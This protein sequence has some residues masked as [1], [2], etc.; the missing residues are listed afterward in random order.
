MSAVAWSDGLKQVTKVYPLAIKSKNWPEIARLAKAG[1]VDQAK[2]LASRGEMHGHIE[3]GNI[4]ARRM[5]MERVAFFKRVV[6]A[7]T[8]L[9]TML[10]AFSRKIT[11]TV[12]ANGHTQANHTRIAKVVHDQAVILRATMKSWINN[13]I[14]DSAKLGFQNIGDAL[15]PIFKHNRESMEQVILAERALFESRVDLRE[16]K[17]VFGMDSG[18]ASNAK[19]DVALGSAKW[20]ATTAKIIKAITKKNL[21]GLNPSDRVWDLTTRAEMD[22]KRII[23]NGLANGQNPAVIARDI[24]KFISPD[25][26]NAS[27]FGLDLGPGVYR[28]PFKNAMR[29]ARTEMNRTYTQS[30]VAF[31]QDKDWVSGVNITLS[32]IHSDVD[33][34]DDLAAGG[35]YDADEAGQL[36]PAHPH[37]MC[38]IT[39]IIDP[40][41]LGET[42][43]DSGSGD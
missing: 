2:Q 43:D 19:P 8:E 29:L 38:Y 14:K 13:A 42:D 34:C 6:M 10:D 16:D 15:L 9:K 22:L 31:A 1:K 18:F 41:Y 35:P 4:I 25:V 26:V 12:M 21:K 32:P 36:I 3:R 7:Q 28:S 33:E 37:C 23:A 20:A 39:P 11:S 5:R 17:L 24:K 30:Q 27:Q 40:K